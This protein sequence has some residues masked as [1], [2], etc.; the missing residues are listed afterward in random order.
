VELQVELTKSIRFGTVIEGSKIGFRLWAPAAKKVDLLLSAPEQ[1][2]LLPMTGAGDGWYFLESDALRVGDKYQF[3]IDGDLAVPDP[4]SRFQPND[5]HGASEIIDPNAFKWEDADWQGRP[6]QEAILYELNVGT[7]SPEGTFKGIENRLDKLVELGV[8]AIELMPLADFPGRW[9]WGYDGV[10]PYAPDANYG[11]P[12][13]LKS[14]VQAAHARNLM[15][16]LD[17]VYNHFGPEGNYLHAYAK[18]F[19]TEKH[20]TP[21]GAAINYDDKHSEVVRSFFIENALYWLQEYHIDGLRLDAV[22]AIKDDSKKHVLKELAERVAAG[23]G[24]RRK[25]HLVL[26]NEENCATLLERDANGKPLHYTAQWNDDAHHAY[27]VLV[28]GERNAYYADYH[29]ESSKRSPIQHL[30]RCLTEGFSYQGE[31]TPLRNGAGRGENSKHLP[32]T[33]FVTFIQNHDQ[34]G[35]RA[36]G[37]RIA[38][39][40]SSEALKAIT[41][42]YLLAP[43]IPMLFMGEEWASKQPFCY[44]CD[45]GPELGPLVT[46]GRRKEFA[47][48]PE[49]SDAKTR[50]RIPDPCSEKTFTSSK[51]D[52]LEAEKPGH[53]QFYSLY[54]QLLTLRK[55]EIVPL[56][57][58]KL[59]SGYKT[60]GD[61]AIFAWWQFAGSGESSASTLALVAN[62]QSKEAQVKS[63]PLLESDKQNML[64]SCILIFKTDGASNWS[65]D[66][67]S[68]SP[69]SVYWLHS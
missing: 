24:S 57:S 61:G 38:S 49:F 62:L 67:R 20:H 33:A 6:W 13:D 52:W 28:T 15:V 60:V 47:R 63:D 55:K 21:W 25:I 10:L 29:A 26:E 19:F 9:G 30:G 37:D 68:L 42:I 4:A 32:P 54:K 40:A 44:F 27:H 48:F 11:R 14:L 39:L 2:V 50:E 69:W 56:L 18:Q 22:H 12:E 58:H 66:C 59:S 45:V 1:E 53:R 3:R 43:A 31:P 65:P 35:N 51:L 5:V 64:K 23:P 41:S 7:F 17:V 8:T 16:F 46:E 36:F 34:V